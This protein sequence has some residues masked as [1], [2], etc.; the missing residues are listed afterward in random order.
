VAV[1][2]LGNIYGLGSSCQKSWSFKPTNNHVT[3]LN[4]KD[5]NLGGIAVTLRRR[6]STNIFVSAATT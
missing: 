5:G 3:A 4:P 6:E 2:D 1:D